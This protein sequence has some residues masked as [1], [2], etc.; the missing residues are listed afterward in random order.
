L[1]F[2]TSRR[3]LAVSIFLDVLNV[4]TLFLTFFSGDEQ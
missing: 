1:P 3:L 2:R 4:F